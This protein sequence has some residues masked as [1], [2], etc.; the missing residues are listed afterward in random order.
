M[1]E[2]TKV[3]IIIPV[4]NVAPYLKR[5]M[6][7]VV[8][9]TLKDIEIIVID[10]CSTDNSLEILKEYASK[11][12]RIKLIALEK[13]SGAAVARNKG[14]EIATGEY[15]GFVDPDD[16]IDLN[17]YEE[18]YKKAKEDGADIAK[19]SRKVIETDGNVVISKYNQHIQK[20]GKY[21]FRVEWTT[22]LYSHLLLNKYNIN[23]RD[24]IRK[25]QD[26]VFL[27]SIIMYVKKISF[28]DTV[29]Y[30]YYRRKDS[31]H[32]SQSSTISIDKLQSAMNAYIAILDIYNQHEIFNKDKEA[33]IS[34]Y[35]QKL[36]GTLSYS[37]QNNTFEAKQICARNLF[38]NMEMCK[39]FPDVEKEVKNKK[40]VNAIKNK[41]EI[42]LA[43]LLGKYKI[44]SEIYGQTG[45]L[46][47]IFS[48][49][50]EKNDFSYYKK[51]TLFGM[52]FR[53]KLRNKV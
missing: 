11:D 14:L 29:F 2:L 20:K 24:D 43:K 34:M 3:S 44:K 45:F 39:F 28:V 37:L 40:I 9:Q 46:Q 33:Y 16:E 19:G 47:K 42:L 51:I 32:S 38:K 18:L 49:R 26:I 31:L 6:D 15:L 5:S 10:D 7:S 8:N 53:W 25:S 4:Y 35:L 52:S 13:N 23:F 41:N 12:N 21:Y 22:A 1:K 36:L 50:N 27:A 30:Y 17:F 48:I